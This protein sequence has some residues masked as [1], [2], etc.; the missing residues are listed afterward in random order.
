MKRF[1]FGDKPTFHFIV[2]VLFLANISWI[3]ERFFERS[4]TP[5]DDLFLINLSFL[6]KMSSARFAPLEQTECLHYNIYHPWLPLLWRLEPH[7][8]PRQ[9]LIKLCIE[10]RI[11]FVFIG[12]HISE[13]L[14]IKKNRFKF[15]V[16][17]WFN[18]SSFKVDC[19]RKQL[20]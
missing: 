18:Y 12:I 13:R 4:M 2:M 6:I 11:E 5:R 15:L 10:F 20:R 16:Q 17:S 3:K 1:N 14:M 7:Q 9:Y 19:I 8:Y